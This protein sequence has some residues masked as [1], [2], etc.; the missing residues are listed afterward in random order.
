MSSAVYYFCWAML[1]VYLWTRHRYRILHK[2][3]IPRPSRAMLIASNHGSYLDPAIIGCAFTYPIWYLA[4]QTLFTNSRFFG[5]FISIVN[6]I[7]ISRE[8]LDLQ[9]LR[10]TRSI[11]H[12]GHGVVIFPEGT[13]TKDGNLQRGL[14]GVGLFADK[15]GVDILP[16][17]VDGSFDSLPRHSG[18]LL[19][20]PTQ[21]TITIGPLMPIKQWEHIAVGRTRYEAIADDIMKAITALKTERESQ[22]AL[23]KAAETPVGA[24]GP[25]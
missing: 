24:G 9:T 2:E 12:A 19:A 17:Y 11:C 16:V 20:R 18:G 5:W 23:T 21:I 22:K 10:R 3:R 13:R 14:A 6:A 1:R 4:R 15:I 7:P 25:A 8:R